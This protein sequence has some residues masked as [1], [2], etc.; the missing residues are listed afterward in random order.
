MDEADDW[1]ARPKRKAFLFRSLKHPDEAALFRTIYGHGFYLVAMH[2]T[3]EGRIATLVQRGM[4]PDSAK[5][6]MAY[7]DKE[8]EDHDQNTRETFEL[9]DFFVNDAGQVNTQVERFDTTVEILHEN[10]RRLLVIL[11]HARNGCTWTV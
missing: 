8:S 7:D 1:E 9:A 11:I 4:D 3:Y 2:S 5:A 10:V 6:V